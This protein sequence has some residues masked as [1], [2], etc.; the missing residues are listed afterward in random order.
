MAAPDCGLIMLE[1]PIVTAKLSNL[2]KAA[3]RF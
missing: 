1:R 3:H 2:S